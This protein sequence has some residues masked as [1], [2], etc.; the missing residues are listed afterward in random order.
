MCFYLHILKIFYGKNTFKLLFNCGQGLDSAGF[1]ACVFATNAMKWRLASSLDNSITKLS[2]KYT[3]L[4]NTRNTLD[5]KYS[6]HFRFL[7]M[8]YSLI[9]CQDTFINALSLPFHQKFKENWDFF[10]FS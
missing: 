7:S 1:H 6:I 9:S 3:L 2:Q 10:Y 4:L 5:T 8:N